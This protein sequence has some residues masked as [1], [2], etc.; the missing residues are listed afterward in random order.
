ML[1]SRSRNLVAAAVKPI[2]LAKV[3]YLSPSSQNISMKI[4]WRVS[5]CG[6]NVL[7]DP[8]VNRTC[9]RQTGYA[10]R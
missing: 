8:R 5:G 6:G 1:P 7:P 10:Q 4:L 3:V 9:L 2:R